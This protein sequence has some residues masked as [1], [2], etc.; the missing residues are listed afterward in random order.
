MTPWVIGVVDPSAASSPT[1]RQA[2]LI[3]ACL[4]VAPAV[5]NAR[6]VVVV[7]G[8]APDAA[9][10]RAI[11]V[12]AIAERGVRLVRTPDG[13]ICDAGP[14]PCA[15]AL[16]AR[17]GADA[18]LRVDVITGE[19]V[20]VRVRLVPAEGDAVEVEE[21]VA[22]AGL[23][24]GVAA[25][26]GRALDVAPPT[27]GFLLVR[28]VPTGATVVIDGETIGSTPLRVTLTPG[29]HEV[30][31]SHAA[32][33]H[34][35]T[36]T[37]VA[38]RETSLE[39]AL[40]VTTEEL[41]GSN[42]L[43]PGPRAIRTE[44]S[45]FNWIIGGALALGGVVTLISPLSTLAREGQCEEAIQDVGCVERV[46]F[47]LQSGF[48]LGIGLAALVAAVAMDT[49]APIRVDVEVDSTGALI[50]VRGRF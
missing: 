8:D 34:R 4:S 15:A 21:A 32:G 30:R 35:S 36:V 26:V 41:D 28:T 7:V 2:L 24:S 1:V 25:A 29:E 14:V 37:V 12:E 11:V 10:L 31:L 22:D 47:G 42:A 6:S 17:T 40:G 9:A 46:R 27:V 20:R 16:A 43:T 13:E 50:G 5:A 44:P 19:P 49:I 18:T 38:E 45:S 33:G 3:I 23:A 48:L 39:P